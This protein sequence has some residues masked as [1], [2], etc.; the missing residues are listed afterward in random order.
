MWR[1]VGGGLEAL[2]LHRPLQPYWP[3]THMQPIQTAYQAL[4]QV[5]VLDAILS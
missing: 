3:P 2:H 5:E 4:D 1:T